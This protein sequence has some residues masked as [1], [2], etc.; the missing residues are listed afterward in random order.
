MR[1]T[2]W[3]WHLTMRAWPA[4]PLR[5]MLLLTLAVALCY[6]NSLTG[7]FQF[8]DYNVIVNE[9][10]VHGWHHWWH[11]LGNG[12]RPLLKFSYLLNWLMGSATWP[13]HLTNLF[14]HLANTLLVWQIAHRYIL[15]QWQRE[16]LFSVPFFAALLFALHP[17]Q[18]EAVSYISGRS[19]SLMTFFYLA[20]LLAYVDGRLQHDRVRR[21]VWVPVLFLLALA[22]KETAV[23]LPFALLLW[24]ATCGGR[25][26]TRLSPVWPSMLVLII[27]TL[28][29]SFNESYLHEMQRSFKLHAL[30]ANLFTQLQG[31]AY[32]FKQWVWPLALNIDPDLSQAS[33]VSVPALLL[34]AASVL[35][36]LLLRH[37][38]PWI[39]L[40]L[41]WMMLHLIPLYLLLPRLDIANE[42]QLYLAAWPLYLALCIE[43]SLTLHEKFLKGV[44]LILVLTLAILTFQRN[45]DYAS[46]IALWESTMRH[47]PNKARVHNNLGMAYLLAERYADA[48]REFST[49]LQLDP[50]L[51]QARYNLMRVDEALSLK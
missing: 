26:R 38:R 39:T 36:A 20:A 35:L 34:F 13:F 21:C 14:I 18:T 45:Q 5:E 49:A 24:E 2:Y 8:D 16:A 10:T 6:A 46:E 7:S 47:S 15:Q 22:C 48:R 4:D 28:Y 37:R 41:C 19:A 50:D 43:L 23:T 31:Y 9:A 42:R 1:W 27:A 12:I 30:E 32:L 3:I 44:M 33:T 25:W 17:V 40:A 11:A 29:F 51:Y